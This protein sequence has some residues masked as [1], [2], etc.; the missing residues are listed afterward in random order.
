MQNRKIE[1]LLRLSHE[2]EELLSAHPLSAGWFALP[3]HE[4]QKLVTNFTNFACLYVHLEDE[5][6]D[7]GRVAFGPTEKKLD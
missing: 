1:T 3:H 5:C 2:F 7:P 4:A 6:R